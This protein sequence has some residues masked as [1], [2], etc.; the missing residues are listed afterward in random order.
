MKIWKRHSAFALPFVVLSVALR[1][2]AETMRL[3][4]WRKVFGWEIGHNVRVHLSVHIPRKLI[5]RLGD[6]VVLARRIEINTDTCTGILEIGNNTNIAQDCSLDVSGKLKIGANVTISEGVAIYTHSHGRNPRRKPIGH[7]V[8][9]DD[10]V[11]ICTRALVL[12]SA[13]TIG[14]RAIIGAGE[15]VREPV[16]SDSLFVRTCEHEAIS[17]QQDRGGK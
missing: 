11:W 7:T 2:V 6:G 8:I 16:P 9:I 17:A 14:A 10:D 3:I 1:R 5:V 4:Y 12:S 15:I 13:R